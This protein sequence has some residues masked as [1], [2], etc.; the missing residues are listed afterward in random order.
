M[1][2]SSS[3]AHMRAVY[4]CYRIINWCM[5]GIVLSEAKMW[6]KLSLGLLLILLVPVQSQPCES[7][8]K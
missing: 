2:Q 7:F 3:Q 5:Q 8:R 4:V 6:T 1:K